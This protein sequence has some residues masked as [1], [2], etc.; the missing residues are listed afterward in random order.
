RSPAGTRCGPADRSRPPAACCGSPPH[1]RP[2]L[3]PAAQRRRTPP[4]PRMSSAS[5]IL[6]NRNG[7]RRPRVLLEATSKT[8]QLLPPQGEGWDGGGVEGPSKPI[9]TL[10]LPL[11]GRELLLRWLLVTRHYVTSSP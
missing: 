4:Q 8:L 7:A 11:K 3:S 10:T 1:A 9:P 6:Q 5:S 2:V